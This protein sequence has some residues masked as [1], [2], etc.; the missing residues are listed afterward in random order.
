VLAGLRST[1]LGTCGSSKQALSSQW[2]ADGPDYGH[3][4]ESGAPA[5]REVDHAII[6]L[7][8]VRS[9]YGDRL[10]TGLRRRTDPDRTGECDA[11]RRTF[12]T[13]ALTYQA[14]VVPDCQNYQDENC[15][16]AHHSHGHCALVA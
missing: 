8:V 10:C 3:C 1:S 2:H 6:D 9:R 14:R 4:D 13:V 16:D 7:H 12:N 11:I 5:C 15:G